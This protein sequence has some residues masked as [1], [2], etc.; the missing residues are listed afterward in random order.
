MARAFVAVRPPEAVLDAIAARMAGVEIAPGRPAPRDQWHLTVQFLGNQVDLDAVVHALAE[1]PFDVSPGRLRL[2]GARAFGNPRRARILALGL[3]EGET[4]MANLAFVVGERLAPLGNTREARPYVAHLT[5]ARFGEPSDLRAICSAIGPE[6]V[7][8][9]W[10]STEVV[11]FESVLRRGGPE[12]TVRA[13]IPT[14][15]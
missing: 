15:I 14:A 6:P 8:D 4:W 1:E 13:V 5:L 12:H 3:Q 10:K 7:G 9:A 11:L 2:A